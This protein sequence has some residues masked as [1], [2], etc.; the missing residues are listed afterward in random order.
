MIVRPFQ[1]QDQTRVV[2]LY[3][4]SLAWYTTDNS[5]VAIPSVL[6]SLAESRCGSDGDLHDIQKSYQT[7]DKRRNFFV[8][9]DESTN[10][11]I[12]FVGAIPS[13]EFDPNEYMELVRMAVDSNYRG[14]GVGKLL[15]DAFEGWATD[16][17]YSKVNL[18]TLD[19][20]RPAMR[21]YPKHGYVEYPEKQ[22]RLDTTKYA[23]ASGDDANAVHLVH[24]V[25]D[26]NC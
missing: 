9:H 15:I 26:L 14:S 23:Q 13:S 11:V 12:G 17:G 7:G 10:T 22:Q 18:T 25:K 16:N 3:A 20:M 24:F 8:C 2:E 1:P 6:K 4:S 5:P 21:F 19:G